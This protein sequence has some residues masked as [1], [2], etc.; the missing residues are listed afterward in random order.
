MMGEGGR[1]SGNTKKISQMPKSYGENMKNVK[2]GKY[3]TYLKNKSI[4]KK[5]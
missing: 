5:N 2:C 3:E 1:K 4:E